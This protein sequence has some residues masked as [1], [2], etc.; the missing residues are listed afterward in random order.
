MKHTSKLQQLHLLVTSEQPGATDSHGCGMK[1]TNKAFDSLDLDDSSSSGISS[2]RGYLSNSE[3]KPCRSHSDSATSRDLSP[4]HNDA[5]LCSGSGCSVISDTSSVSLHDVPTHHIFRPS[6]RLTNTP[7]QPAN[8][9]GDSVDATT[10]LGFVTNDSSNII[11]NGSLKPQRQNNRNELEQSQA[12]R[13]CRQLNNLCATKQHFGVDWDMTDLLRD[14]SRDIRACNPVECQTIADLRDCSSVTAEPSEES[15][16]RADIPDSQTVFS[17]S[18]RHRQIEIQQVHQVYKQIA[19]HCDQVRQKAWPR[20]KQFLKELEP[21]SLVADV[22]CGNGRYL[23]INPT[24]FKL[25]CDLCPPFL[26]QA[27]GQGHEVMVADNIALP[28]RDGVF[29]AVISIGVIHHFSSLERR[30]M[31]VSELSRILSPGGK[32]MVYVWAFEQAHRKFEGQDV[33]IPWVKPEVKGNAP[34]KT[35]SLQS[36]AENERLDSR[37]DSCSVDSSDASTFG[38]RKRADNPKRLGCAGEKFRSRSLDDEDSFRDVCRDISILGGWFGSQTLGKFDQRV[39][40]TREC[41]VAKKG[42]ILVK[43]TASL[44]K[45]KHDCLNRKDGEDFKVAQWPRQL[46]SECKKLGKFLRSLSSRSNSL[47]DGEANQTDFSENDTDVSTNYEFHCSTDHI[48]PIATENTES[49]G[50]SSRHGTVT[51]DNYVTKVTSAVKV[52]QFDRRKHTQDNNNGLCGHDVWVESSCAAMGSDESIP[53]VVSTGS[54][55]VYNA[56]AD[57]TTLSG[58]STLHNSIPTSKDIK[59]SEFMPCQFRIKLSIPTQETLGPVSHEERRHESAADEHDGAQSKLTSNNYIEENQVDIFNNPAHSLCDSDI[60]ASSKG[61]MT[62]TSSDICSDQRSMSSY[63]GTA[64]TKSQSSV[65]S[66]S[67]TT[68]TDSQFS[69][70]T[71]ISAHRICNLQE[72]LST[73]DVSISCEDAPKNHSGNSIGTEKGILDNIAFV[74]NFNRCLPKCQNEFHTMVSERAYPDHKQ[75]VGETNNPRAER[76]NATSVVGERLLEMPNYTANLERCSVLSSGSAKLVDSS[77]KQLNILEAVCQHHSPRHNGDSLDSGF[78]DKEN[79]DI[80]L[81]KATEDALE[82]DKTMLPAAQRL[83]VTD[84][85]QT[86][87]DSTLPQEVVPFRGTIKTFLGKLAGYFRPSS[88]SGSNKFTCHHNGNSAARKFLVESDSSDFETSVSSFSSHSSC[89]PGL[90]ASSKER[91]NCEKRNNICGQGPYETDMYDDD[92]EII[93]NIQTEEDAKRTNA[94]DVTDKMTCLNI[95]LAENKQSFRANFVNDVSETFV[96]QTKDQDKCVTDEHYV[97]QVENISLLPV[98][99]ASF[100]NNLSQKWAGLLGKRSGANSGKPC[101]HYSTACVSSSSDENV[102]RMKISLTDNEALTTSEDLPQR[103]TLARRPNSLDFSKKRIRRSGRRPAPRKEKLENITQNSKDVGLLNRVRQIQAKAQLSLSDAM[104]LLGDGVAEENI[105]KRL[106]NPAKNVFAEMKRI[107]FAMRKFPMSSLGTGSKEDNTKEAS[108]GDT[109]DQEMNSRRQPLKMRRD[110]RIFA[111]HRGCSD[112]VAT[113]DCTKGKRR[114]FHGYNKVDGVG[115]ANLPGLDNKCASED[116]GISFDAIGGKMCKSKNQ[117]LYSSISD[118]KLDLLALL[119]SSVVKQHGPVSLQNWSNNAHIQPDDPVSHDTFENAQHGATSPRKDLTAGV[120]SDTEKK[121]RWKYYA[122]TNPHA[123]N[124]LAA[125]PFHKLLLSSHRGFSESLGAQDITEDKRQPFHGHSKVEGVGLTKLRC[126]DHKC[127]SEDFGI[128]F[129]AIGGKLC[130]SKHQVLYSSI[131]DSQPDLLAPLESSVEDQQGHASFQNW[132]NNAQVTPDVPVSADIFG[133]TQQGATSTTKHLLDGVTVDTENK[134]RSQYAVGTNPHTASILAAQ[135]C[136]KRLLASHRGFSES[137]GAQDSIINK[138]HHFHEHSKVDGVGLTKLRCLDNKCASEDFEISFDAIGGKLCKSKHQVLYSSINDSKQDLFA[139][140]KTPTEKQQSLV[141]FPNLANNARHAA[142]DP[143]SFDSFENTQQGANSTTK[144]LLN[145][146]TVETENEPRSQYDRETNPH[147]ANVLACR[148][149][150]KL[151]LASHRG[152]SESLGAQDSTKDK[153]HPFNGHSK[154]EGVGLTKL[155]CLDNKCASEDFGISFDAIGGKL[156]KS[157]HQ[158]LYSSINDSEPD[159]ESSVE[160]QQGH[161]SFQN[162]TNS[163]QV[164]QEKSI[165]SDT[166]A[167]TQQGTTLTTKHFLDEVAMDTENKSRSNNSHAPSILSPQ[168]CIKRLL[169]SNRGFSESLGAQDSTKSKGHHFHHHSKV[170]GVGLTNLRCLDN[171]CASE[172]FGISFDSIGGKL[173]KSKYQILNCSVSDSQRD[174]FALFQS[175]AEKQ[176]SPIDFQNWTNNAQNSA[177]DP[178]SFVSFEN[179]Q[180]GSNFTTKHLLDG[181]AEDTENKGRSQYAEGTNPHAASIVTAQPCIKR[182]L[183]SHREFSESLGAQDSTKGKRQPFHGHTKVDGVGLAN[184]RGLD[185]KCASEDFGISFDSI[186]GKLCKSNYQVLYSSFS[187]SQRDLFAPPESSTGKQGPVRFQNWSKNPHVQQE[188][189]VSAETFENTQQ[190]ATSPR[191][192]LLDRVAVGIENKSHSTNHNEGNILPAEPY[193]TVLVC[194]K[195]INSFDELM[196]ARDLSKDGCSNMGN[197]VNFANPEAVTNNNPATRAKSQILKDRPTRHSSQPRTVSNERATESKT[198]N[199]LSRYYHVFKKGE[200]DHLVTRYV[201]S[202]RIVDT[203]Y[204]H[205]NWCIIVEKLTVP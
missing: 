149:L 92:F 35:L 99:K 55:Q 66:Y 100:F 144:H 180:Q 81:D 131:S 47:G 159:L 36:E 26:E 14:I 101:L 90:F 162:W 10:V 98:K 134:T 43:N 158:V 197:D 151:L 200:L 163:S 58:G 112:S 204:D 187:D 141:N 54:C 169:S 193:N 137:L 80:N 63:S 108:A 72:S 53:A 2:E 70:N 140:L 178:I 38:R 157:K 155:R 118:S 104:T 97:F 182:V 143:V 67:G 119:E 177:E 139:V 60:T 205:A 75:L 176:K 86:L 48:A 59:D 130:K 18:R 172:D 89:Y 3:R 64:I 88:K 168:P 201:P 69:S 111:A 4:D 153:R 175:S 116:L 85:R 50:D 123:A 109:C 23:S 194:S 40:K 154:V 202:L 68:I 145:G 45:S 135:P 196:E 41:N 82:N 93:E 21:G 190:G 150:N 96:A 136:M 57:I 113:Q 9:H 102:E 125:K 138:R 198:D 142:K 106:D 115:L 13:D 126:L 203:F 129:D 173:C 110:K 107:N 22:G 161:A 83:T 52:E 65:S 164:D 33:L 120:D 105:V 30:I 84:Q 77:A 188:D 191:K 124:T 78:R 37:S 121:L 167:N 189:P 160:D 73:Q 17:K 61:W 185:N 181:V 147:A 127:A 146:V 95:S 174:L 51:T 6:C 7:T 1:E 128:S 91:D 183:S 74:Q 39:N 20:V 179:T 114:H 133:N 192:D 94:E 166:F 165:Y 186:G 56:H 29:D 16:P 11:N 148:P 76:S 195:D 24:T 15:S 156:C 170:D 87:L 62:V 27:R 71:N 12:T 122:G 117:V 28:F 49:A 34:R 199:S 132:T 184:L 79:S 103:R 31:A 8:T 32:L 25:G 5:N 152:F 46:V 171:K 42:N 19:P 44:N